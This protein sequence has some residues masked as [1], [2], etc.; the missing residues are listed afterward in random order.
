MAQ[1]STQVR[2]Q[3]AGFRTARR[4]AARRQKTQ[5]RWVIYAGLGV[6]ALALVV[7]FGSRALQSASTPLPGEPVADQGAAHIKPGESHPPYNTNPPTSGWHYDVSD[8]PGVYDSPLID[9]EMVHSLEHGYVIIAYNCGNL[10]DA[11]CQALKGKLKALAERQRLW[12][13]IV[14]PRPNLDTQIALTAWRRIDKLNSYDEDRIVR[15]INAWRDKGP[16]KTED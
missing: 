6:L 8:K 2:S 1:K 5:P 3:A 11:D 9:E 16:E 4:P 12:K 10:S 14:V 13:L 15:F 7:F